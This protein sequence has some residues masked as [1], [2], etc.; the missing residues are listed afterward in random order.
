MSYILFGILGILGA[1]VFILYGQ[2]INREKSVLSSGLVIAAI[3]YIFFAFFWGDAYWIGIETLGVLFYSAF[4]FLGKRLDFRW[5]GVG[6]LLHPIWDVVLHLYGGGN[7]VA[8]EWY[9]VACL[10]FDFVVA[11]YIFWKFPKNKS[12]KNK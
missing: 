4:Y 10:T 11:S 5:L 3:I 1:Y 8:P 12:S 6:W 2:K 9:A 7:V